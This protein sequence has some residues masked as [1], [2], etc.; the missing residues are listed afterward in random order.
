MVRASF[1]GS[2]SI[3]RVAYPG[4]RCSPKGGEKKRGSLWIPSIL[5]DALWR[6]VRP[7]RVDERV[8]AVACTRIDP[9]QL[10]SVRAAS[11]SGNNG[12]TGNVC[13]VVTAGDVDAHLP[14]GSGRG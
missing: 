9:M 1:F 11:R 7:D 2:L 12:V 10:E 6:R 13:G 5:P 3:M 4:V 8:V 14:C